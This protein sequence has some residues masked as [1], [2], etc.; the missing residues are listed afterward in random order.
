M[1]LA[2]RWRKVE[3]GCLNTCYTYI[4]SSEYE[5]IDSGLEALETLE[6]PPD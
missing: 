6:S 1:E 3:E 5:V 4:W 2:K